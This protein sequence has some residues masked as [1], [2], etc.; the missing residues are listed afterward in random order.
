MKLKTRLF[1]F[2]AMMGIIFSVMGIRDWM[3]LSKTPKDITDLWDYDYSRLKAGDHVC[4][5]VTL[6]W[7][8]IGSSIE[9]TK[10]MGVTT[11]ERETGRYYLIPFC[12]E[13]DDEYIY[14]TPYLLA[15]IPS[16]YNSALDAQISKTDTWWAKD[17]DFSTVPGSTL[18]FDG[19]LVKIPNKLRK[20]IEASVLDGERL[21]DYM[22]PVMF[23]PIANPGAAK[24]MSIIGI[25]CL[26]ITVAI[27]VVMLKQRG[28]APADYGMPRTAKNGFIPQATDMAGT[29][30]GFAG[31]QPQNTG[32][33]GMPTGAQQPQN[34]GSFGFPSANPQPQNTI[35]T[36]GMASQQS[37]SSGPAPLGPSQPLGSSAPT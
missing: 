35:G 16:R 7:D 10:T 32:S 34:N 15:E 17:E 23:E 18:H 22:L 37:A 2:L 29:A 1:I 31:Q 30:Q 25:I 19:K 20:D 33:F 8:T 12:Q 13:E 6:V 11:S 28:S 3:C 5:D 14:P 26:G 21:E 4:F 9:Q 36:F 24:G 27:L